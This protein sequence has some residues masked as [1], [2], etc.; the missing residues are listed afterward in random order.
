MPAARAIWP[1]GC[2][3]LHS[4]ESDAVGRSAAA[5]D[6]KSVAPVLG[7]KR[8]GDV[9]AFQCKAIRIELRVAGVAR[10]HAAVQRE[11]LAQCL[12]AARSGFTGLTFGGGGGIAMP[13]NRSETH[14]PRLT[15]EVDVPLAVTF[16][17]ADCVHRPPKGVSCGKF[18][19]GRSKPATAG[20][21]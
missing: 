5:I 19:C 18:T 9:E 13:S 20:K 4:F 15:G 21:P 14:T 1:T 2:E 10:A 11:L 16:M 3:I 6:G 17:V 7:A 8:S 12:G